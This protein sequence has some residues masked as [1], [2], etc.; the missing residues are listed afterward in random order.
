M[1]DADVCMYVM[2][3]VWILLTPRSK[4]EREIDVDVVVEDAKKFDKAKYAE[5]LAA[6]NGQCLGG[7]LEV[8]L[9]CTYRIASTGPKTTMG[10]PEVMLGLLP[11]AGGT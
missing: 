1:M 11:G 6:I 10:L 7:G 2:I 4:V 3:R 9:A 8:A 5:T